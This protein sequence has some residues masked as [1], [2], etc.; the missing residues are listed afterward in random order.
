MHI[1]IYSFIDQNIARQMVDNQV[2]LFETV[3]C[4]RAEDGTFPPD[5]CERRVLALSGHTHTLE[6]IRPGETFEGWETTLDSGAL[7]PGRSAGPSPFPQIVTGAACGAWWSGDF[8]SNVVPEGWQRLGGPRGYLIFEF[9]G[10]TY[11]DVFK[12]TGKA[13]DQQ[14][15]IDLL[16]PSFVTWF[17]QLA[18]WRNANPAA[19]AVPPTNINEL[20][21]TKQVTFAELGETYLSANVWNGSKESIVTVSIDG[22]PAQAM[23][24]SQAGA[25]ENILETLDPYA[26]K[27]QM[28]IARHAYVTSGDA[29]ANGFELFSGSQRCPPNA[30]CTPR[31]DS[32]FFWTDQSQHI[33]QIKLPADLTEGAH[34]A[35]VTVEDHFGRIFEESFAFEVVAE[36]GF[37]YWNFDNFSVRP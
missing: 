24:R 25:G 16:T 30:P 14:M 33:W 10:N 23:V 28:M 21:D 18:A 31:P 36:R 32:S 37:K 6:Q 4:K 5:E 1:P 3:G 7:P 27:R 12:A 15:S 9:N 20:L 17:R 8:D 2:E 11:K 34:I 35:K 26:L 13:A 19:D 22:H 29:R